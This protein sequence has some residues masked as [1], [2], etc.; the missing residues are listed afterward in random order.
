MTRSQR[1]RSGLVKGTQLS[2]EQQE[3]EEP[4]IGLVEDLKKCSP[5]GLA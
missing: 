1:G 5:G 3:I 2:G 4:E